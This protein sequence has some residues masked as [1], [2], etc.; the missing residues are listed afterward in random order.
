MGRLPSRAPPE[1]QGRAVRGQ[2]LSVFCCLFMDSKHTFVS[3][4]H[5]RS[6][7]L[8]WKTNRQVWL[9]RGVRRQRAQRPQWLSL[10]RFLTR[11]P[12]DPRGGPHS[13]WEG[14]PGG[15]WSGQGRRVL[16][17]WDVEQ[18]K[19][20]RWPPGSACGCR[21]GDGADGS[22]SVGTQRSCPSA[23][24]GGQ[25]S[26]RSCRCLH[27]NLHFPGLLGEVR[28]AVP[29]AGFRNRVPG[30]APQRESEGSVVRNLATFS[31][32]GVRPVSAP[33]SAGFKA[34]LFSAP[35]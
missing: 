12:S 32:G 18:S 22:E 29:G 6:Q 13:P 19:Q 30:P 10:P 15:T 25:P 23:G 1:L 2:V 31:A 17:S 21:A 16:W 4:G 26:L 14:H 5:S 27:R 20:C 34:G 11:D 9:S 24:R 28:D 7:T 3:L 8:G 33:R 35:A